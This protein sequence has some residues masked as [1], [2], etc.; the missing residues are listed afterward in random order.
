MFA[1][2]LSVSTGTNIYAHFMKADILLMVNMSNFTSAVNSSYYKATPLLSVEKNLQTPSEKLSFKTWWVMRNTLLTI[3]VFLLILQMFH[4]KIIH[5]MFLTV[6]TIWSGLF[7]PLQKLWDVWKMF[8]LTRIIFFVCFCNTAEGCMW[9]L[10]A[11]Q[12]CYIKHYW[13]CSEV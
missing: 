7:C 12:R 13:A 11:T 4:M 5:V 6:L 8:S 9:T 10:T 2:T 3:W 1:S